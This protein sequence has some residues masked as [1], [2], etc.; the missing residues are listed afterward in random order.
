LKI[1][2][3]PNLPARP[4]IF[5]FDRIPMQTPKQKRPDDIN[6]AQAIGKRDSA[7]IV[8]THSTPIASYAK[9]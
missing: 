4:E 9:S 1:D 5:C 8:V 3:L 2:P 6:R 7:F